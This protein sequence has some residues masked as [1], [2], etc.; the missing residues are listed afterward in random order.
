MLEFFKFFKSKPK[1]LSLEARILL[2]EESVRILDDELIAARRRIQKF[3]DDNPITKSYATTIKDQFYQ[4][5]KNFQII[6]ET[7]ETT[8][9][10]IN[11][12]KEAIELM[13]AQLEILQTLLFQLTNALLDAKVI[14]ED[15]VKP[16]LLN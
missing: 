10:A 7:A 14:S 8:V 3:E 16:P 4:I 6:K 12:H 9:P 1:K 2:L 13:A 5:V 15:D 11:S